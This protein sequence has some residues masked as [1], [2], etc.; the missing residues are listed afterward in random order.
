LRDD[1]LGILL[2]TH[3]LMQ[4]EC[5]ADRV[6]FMAEGRIV[7]EGRPEALIRERFGD[8]KELS[9]ALRRAASD[10]ETVLLRSLGLAPSVRPLTWTG[11]LPM[12]YEQVS[13]LGRRLREA[14]MPLVEINL[15]EP[16]LAALFERM[17]GRLL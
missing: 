6:A 10:E 3:D 17:T 11:M 5:L 16:G 15:R 12:G 9:V 2:T 13:V 8:A 7:G 14:G 1:G 4:A